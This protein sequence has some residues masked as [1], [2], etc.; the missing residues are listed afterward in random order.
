MSATLTSSR[1][2]ADSVILVTG[3][4]SG[5]GLAIAE[6]FL[7]AGASVAVCARAQPGLD[8][9][10]ARHPGTLAIS[11][12]VTDPRDRTAMLDTVAARSDPKHARAN[13]AR[14]TWDQA[15]L[16]G[17]W[18]SRV[19]RRCQQVAADP[20]R[21]AAAAPRASPPVRHIAAT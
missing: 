21:R 7:D 6:A 3:G 2:F 12:D 10:M 1:A 5:I 19:P 17:S 14:S 4:T 15:T 9:F 16:H 8:A 20:R 18:H 11:A 13:S